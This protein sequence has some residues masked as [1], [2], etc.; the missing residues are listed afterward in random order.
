MG[1]D[2][3]SLRTLLHRRGLM[4]LGA[5]L[6]GQDPDLIW[7]LCHQLDIGRGGAVM[8]LCTKEA[9]SEIARRQIE[10]LMGSYEIFFSF[11]WTRSS[12]RSREKNHPERR[13]QHLTEGERNPP[14]CSKRSG[15]FQKRDRKEAE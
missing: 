3:E 7:T 12:S 5:G 9:A 6:F 10:E 1:W 14:S 4:R 11:I 2:G 8:K 13:I 15:K